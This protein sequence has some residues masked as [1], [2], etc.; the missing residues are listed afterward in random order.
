MQ[1][2]LDVYTDVGMGPL[3]ANIYVEDFCMRRVYATMQVVQY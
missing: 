3:G 1:G 2:W